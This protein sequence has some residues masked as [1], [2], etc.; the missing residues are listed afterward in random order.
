MRI[1]LVPL[2]TRLRAPETNLAR[3]RARLPE[4]RAA[5]PDV[6]VLPELTLSGYVYEDDDLRR[7]AEPIP[8]PLTAQ[9]ADVARDVQAHLVFGLMERAPEGVYDSAVWLTPDGTLL[10]VQRKLSEPPPFV[11]GQRLERIRTP[12][13]AARILICGDVFHEPA[14]QALSG[15]EACI[16][17]PLARSFD[18][19]SPDAERWEREERAEY[20]AAARALRRPVLFVNALDEDGDAPAFGGAMAVDAQGQLIGE[21]PHGTDALLVVEIEASRAG[22]ELNDA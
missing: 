12:W 19:R 21:S 20:L 6:V 9:M 10:A 22:E 2:H 16:L 17:V 11:K 8:G 18:G 7:F 13:G 15:D 5:R 4:L 3:L 14:R 1:A